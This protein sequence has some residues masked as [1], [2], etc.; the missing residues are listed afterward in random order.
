[1]SSDNSIKIPIAEA[2]LSEVHQP[3]GTFDEA[4]GREI[5]NFE[6]V[7]AYAHRLGAYA[8]YVSYN[9]MLSKQSA[10]HNSSTTRNGHGDYIVA[11]VAKFPPTS[12]D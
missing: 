7:E 11:L 1:M 10:E 3:S 8:L 9:G 4:E 6:F 12:S 5:T 2:Y